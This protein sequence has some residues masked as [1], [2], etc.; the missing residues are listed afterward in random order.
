MRKYAEICALL[1]TRLR[2]W[3]KGKYTTLMRNI[4]ERGMDRTIIPQQEEDDRVASK[5]NT[6]VLAGKVR[7]AERQVVHHKGMGS[8]DPF[9]IDPKSDKPVNQVLRETHS[10][11]RILDL[12][13]EE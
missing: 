8:L 9:E 7:S 4:E 10:D 12:D 11:L 1:V 3:R 2:M 5:C 6:M 13:N